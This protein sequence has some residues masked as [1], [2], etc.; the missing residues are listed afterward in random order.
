[1]AK[2]RTPKSFTLTPQEDLFSPGGPEILS[3]SFFDTD[4]GLTAL[5]S[6]GYI[7]RGRLWRGTLWKGDP[8][9]RQRWENLIREALIRS[10]DIGAARAET[11]IA[12]APQ[13]F[14]ELIRRCGFSQHGSYVYADLR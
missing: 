8:D 6:I 7:S 1:M 3:V 12:G 2:R 4:G 10:S 11:H 5:L 14:Q 9:G 13:W